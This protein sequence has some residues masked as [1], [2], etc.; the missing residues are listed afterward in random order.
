[1]RYKF[2][3]CLMLTDSGSSGEKGDDIQGHRRPCIRVGGPDPVNS[4]T[5]N[6]SQE[7][8]RGKLVILLSFS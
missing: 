3:T 2:Y 6:G 8:D 5:E 4:D 1:M 7:D